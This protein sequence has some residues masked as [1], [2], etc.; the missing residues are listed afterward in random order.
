LGAPTA[1]NC[2]RFH[3]PDRKTLWVPPPSK[4]GKKIMP[5]RPGGFGAPL[6]SA[7]AA[8]PMKTLE[9][10][11][12]QPLL[13]WRQGPPSPVFC[14][15]RGLQQE[16]SVFSVRF[17]RSE[18]IQLITAGEKKHLSPKI[19]GLSRPRPDK[20]ATVAGP[21][22]S[23]PPGPTIRDLFAPPPQR[24]KFIFSGYFFPNPQPV[25]ANDGGLPSPAFGGKTPV[26]PAI[27]GVESCRT[28]RCG[29][30]DPSFF[31]LFPALWAL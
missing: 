20:P 1:F 10:C 21:H 29:E 2:F 9:N 6:P 16:L 25:L 18:K 7:H 8:R 11:M 31:I 19:A 22:L 27:F 23:A 12:S 26:S 28:G 5:P 24:P 14:Q 13:P 15:K 4:R 17:G 3:A 30:F